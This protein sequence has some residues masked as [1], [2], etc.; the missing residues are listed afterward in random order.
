MDGKSPFLVFADS[1]RHQLTEPLPGYAAQ[2]IMS[3][4]YRRHEEQSSIEGKECLEAAILALLYP[5]EKYVARLLLTLRPTE[6][7]QH[8][9]QVAFPGGRRE[10]GEDLTQTALRETEEEIF[11]DRT[12]IEILGALTPL[13]IPP[14]RF[15]VYPFI[16]CIDFAPD[17]DVTS[18]EIESVF[19]VSISQ[20]LDQSNRGIHGRKVQEHDM[21]VPH[22]E[23]DGHIVWGAT[24][25]MLSELIVVIENDPV[26]QTLS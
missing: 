16:G 9:G 19:S 18:E 5:S 4:L 15:C 23:L 22:F 12:E 8:G 20:L 26:A 1:L 25:M 17:M 13:F 2:G 6:M 11:I 21:E 24:A 3:P 7:K 10:P 14:S